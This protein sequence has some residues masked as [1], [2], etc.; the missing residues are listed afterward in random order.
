VGEACAHVVRGVAASPYANRT[1]PSRLPRIRAL[2]AK[3]PGFAATG[4]VRPGPPQHPGKALLVLT[5]V[6]RVESEVAERNL[7]PGNDYVEKA[8]GVDVVGGTALRM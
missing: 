2:A 7:A 1:L 3:E 6:F 8:L 5:H 4:R